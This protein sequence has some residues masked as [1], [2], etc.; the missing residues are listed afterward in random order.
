MKS[1]KRQC[2]STGLH[3][4]KEVL[5]IYYNLSFRDLNISEAPLCW[6][7]RG[8]SN[9][10]AVSLGAPGPAQLC[11]FK[12]RKDMWILKPDDMCRGRGIEMASSLKEIDQ[13]IRSYFGGYYLKDYQRFQILPEGVEQGVRVWDGLALQCD[14]RSQSAPI[15]KQAVDLQF[16]KPNSSCIEI[17][18]VWNK[19]SITKDRRITYR[20]N[21]YY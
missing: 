2:R 13:L 10:D 14:T 18:S 12:E 11:F 6:A 5:D 9:A 16:E 17:R 4:P 8:F 1:I 20:T 21:T 15:K 19:H 7:K 3:A